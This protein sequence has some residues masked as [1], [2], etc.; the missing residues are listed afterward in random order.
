MGLTMSNGP[1]SRQDAVVSNYRIDGPEHLLLF[2]DFP[3]RVR[4]VFADVAVLDTTRGRLLH[5]T[6]SLPM[7]YVP[8]DDVTA[9]VLQPTDYVTH[10]PYK[11]DATYWTVQV[12]DR[13]AQNAV[14]GHQQPLR[15]A[16]WLGGYR[17]V[18]WDAMD[19]WYDEDEQ[20]FGHLRDP[21]HRVDV[22][23]ASGRVRVVADGEVLAESTRAKVLSETGLPNRYYL[24]RDDVHV[25]LLPSATA[26]V[27]PY[28][29]TAS[30][31][32]TPLLDELA[33]SYEKPLEDSV[34]ISGYL[35]FLHDGLS[36][37][38]DRT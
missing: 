24:P 9:S 31:W 22:R 32:S 25:S 34:K 7:L 16:A 36:V 12:G 3:R 5:E 21:Y 1:L 26:T 37:Q 15:S 6:G 11:G 27:C 19:A 2:D 28:K 23:E 30:Y 8:E 10:C 35:C 4:A 38:V 29:G 18:F 20:V 33:W 17:A 13:T 14:W